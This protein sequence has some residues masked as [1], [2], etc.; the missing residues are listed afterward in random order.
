M[1]NTSHDLTEGNFYAPVF[2]GMGSVWRFDGVLNNVK[3]GHR[4]R[5]VFKTNN[6]ITLFLNPEADRLP[7]ERIDITP[8]KF[9]ES[10]EAH[11]QAVIYE[12]GFAGIR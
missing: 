10:L 12:M 7:S 6:D 4:N 5:F 8:E 9:E 1:N 3:T 11:V 2:Y